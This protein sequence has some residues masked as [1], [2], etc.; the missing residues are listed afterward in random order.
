TWGYDLFHPSEAILFHQYSR[1]GRPK[2]WS[3]HSDGAEVALPW[4]ERDR[5]SRARAAEF[6]RKPFI[7]RF[8]CGPY[9]SAAQYQEYVG[10]DFCRRIV[11]D[12]TLL[13]GEPPNPRD[14]KWLPVMQRRV[15]IIQLERSRLQSAELTK[16]KFWRITVHDEAGV[17]RYE[18]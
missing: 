5:L 9:R 10:I 2:H 4:Y 1:E 6:L 18:T 14:S 7:G 3:D 15:A 13:G 12:Y 11:Q 17:Q 8:G 16:A